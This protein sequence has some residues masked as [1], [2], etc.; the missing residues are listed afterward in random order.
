MPRR[1]AKAGTTNESARLRLVAGFG[2]T[3]AV[4]KPR[5]V[6]RNSVSLVLRAPVGIAMLPQCL[7]SQES[8][9]DSAPDREAGAEL[10]TRADQGDAEAQFRLGLSCAWK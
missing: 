1:P 9:F 2:I 4:M 6:F 3:T 8:R 7:F 10:R 5:L